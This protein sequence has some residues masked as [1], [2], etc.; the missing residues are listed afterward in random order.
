LFAS[1]GNYLFFLKQYNKYLPP[2][3]TTLSYALLGNHFHFGIRIHSMDDLT[4]FLKVFKSTLNAK[5]ASRP[6]TKCPLLFL[7]YQ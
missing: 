5:R 4:T 2:V 6:K 3:V 1:A 7:M